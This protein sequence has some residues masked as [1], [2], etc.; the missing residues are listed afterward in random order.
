MAS[1]RPSPPRWAT[2]LLRWFCAPH[3]LDEMEGDLNELFHERV[4]TVGVQK[5]RWRYIRDVV[6]L[7]R[8]SLIKRQKSEYPRPTHTDMIRNYLTVAFRN[9]AKNRVY[10]FINITGLASGMAVAMLIGLWVWD[11]LS[12]NKY[13]QNYDRIATV[14]RHFTIDGKK[15]TGGQSSPTPLGQELRSSFSGD[16]THVV[17]S[18]QPVNYIIAN[19]DDEFTQS[20]RFMQSEAPD[21][22]S[23]RMLRGSRASLRETNSILLS[24]SLAQ[25]LFGGA[26]PINQ[27]VTIDTKAEAKVTGVYKD[28]PTNSE[29]KDVTYIAPFDLYA[30]INPWVKEAQDKWGENNFP[31]Y[32]QI[33]P[34]T[35]FEQVSSKLKNIMLK[36]LDAKKAA[37][38]PE[39]FLHPMS[40]WHLYSTFENG[41]KVTSEGVKFVWFYGIIGVFVLL[42][43]CINFMNLSTAR[44]EK[45]AKEVGIRKAVG[46]QR[47]QLVGQFLSESLLM[48]GLAFMVCLGIVQVILPW[49]NG[50]ADKTIALLW[51]NPVFW[52]AGLTF[53]GFTALLAGSYPAF[54]LSSLQPIRT[55][56]GG[57]L[58]GRSAAYSRKLLVVFQFTISI[59]LIIGT[60]VV[61]HQIQFVKN[62]PVGYSR[63]GLLSFPENGLLDK[64]DV[65]RGELLRT[66]VVYEVAESASPL[67][68]VGSNN[69]GF[70]WTGKVPGADDDFGTLGVSYEY[71]KTI[72]WQFVAGRDFS[73]QFP[74]DS[75]G[76]VVNEAAVKVMGLK[77]PVGE[78]VRSDDWH[79]GTFRILGVIK[80]M[81]MDSPF[82]PVRPTIFSLRGY[83][84][85]LFVKINPQT[86][87]NDALSK[88]EAVFKAVVPSV[89]FEYKF[90]DDEYRAKFGA[91]E[92]IGK[93]STFFAGLAVLISCLGIFGLASFTAEQRTKEIGIRKVLGASVANVWQMLSK[94]FVV[95][96]L[97]ACL[98]AVPIA[99]YFMSGWLQNYQ[100][101]TELSWWIFAVAILGAVLLTLLTVSFQAIKAALVNP[102]KSLRSE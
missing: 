2:R 93:L 70:E 98:I 71:G 67:T 45:R 58:S 78:I 46:S 72:G 82:E 87:V 81:V 43:A 85:W 88:I 101:R 79:K 8:P 65:L 16:F 24:A 86:S 44:S 38:K 80:D 40:Q 99:Y 55:L 11:E 26:D 6:S 48:A 18:T 100:Y 94:D 42:L 84:R 97:I 59:A 60:L 64:V 29:F 39:V 83:K 19:G 20:G 33:A 17:M 41:V 89:P 51:T 27:I 91:E 73:R 53:T 52:I 66:G 96:V 10:S 31:I 77:K 90:V 9:L 15:E 25:K 34:H 3:R 5:A 57:I 21:M 102:V 92:R 76:L 35:T 68:K 50:V 75:S 32:V 56:K 95:L 62:R 74:S 30:S 22:L 61:H 63:N 36:H 47:A 1:V 49:F 14:L 37:Q 13:H 7:M 23:L 4:A 54:Y 69:T 28:L 12:Y